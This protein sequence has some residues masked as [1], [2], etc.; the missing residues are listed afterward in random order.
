MKINFAY[1][2]QKQWKGFLGSQ[3]VAWIF[4]QVPGYMPQ[5]RI[6]N[7]TT[8]GPSLP[9]LALAKKWINDNST[10]RSHAQRI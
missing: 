8:Y 1:V 4:Q 9:T 6:D 10:E 7:H 5:L 2:G 3:L